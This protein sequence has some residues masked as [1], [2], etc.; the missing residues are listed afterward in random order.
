MRALDRERCAF[1]I[2]DTERA[3]GIPAESELLQISLQMLLADAVEA[4]HDATLED[5]KEAF[6]SV[7][8]GLA[9]ARNVL[10]LAVVDDA[11]R[12]ELAR[13]E[14]VSKRVVGVHGGRG[15]DVLADR[16]AQCLRGHVG[17]VIDADLA[18][19]FYERVNCVLLGDWLAL[20]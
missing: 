6:R 16:F 1:R 7:D 9:V 5:R 3:A 19:A 8:V 15:V 18:A 14:V 10:V 4:A 11:M 13:H 20:T 12:R 17:N 2:L